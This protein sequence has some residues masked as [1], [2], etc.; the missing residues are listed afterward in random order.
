MIVN[1]TINALDVTPGAGRAL[2]EKLAGLHHAHE[3]PAG[4]M[5]LGKPKIG[6]VLGAGGARGW[7]HI[8]VLRALESIGIH[9]DVIAGTSIGAVVG[10]A[11]AADRLGALEDW[12]RAQTRRSILGLIDAR[13]TG[14]GVVGG[15]GIVAMLRGLGMPGSI[16]DLLLPFIAVATDLRTGREVWLRSG[17]LVG[18]VRASVAIPGLINPQQ[19][20]GRWLVDG[21]LVNPVPVSAARAMGADVVIAVNPNAARSGDFWSPGQGLRGLPDLGE[22]LPDGLRELWANRPQAGGDAEPAYLAVVNAALDITSD[23]IRRSRL[24]GDPPQV[25]LGAN[26]PSVAVLDFHRAEEAITEG[27][28]I[29]EMQQEWIRKA[30]AG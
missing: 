15:A 22:L 8:G 2:A 28:R 25:L 17:D 6:L 1:A 11:R 16:E 9:P 19:L 29:V 14:G 7:C 27:W 10:A 21:G 30:V 18:A 12:A 26:L 4:C 13:L 24:A 5:H 3:Q 23:Q 20:D